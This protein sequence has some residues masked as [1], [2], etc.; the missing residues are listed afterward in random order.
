MI[1]T[2]LRRP[3]VQ[4]ITGLS[5]AGIYKLM[6]SGKFPEPI[7][8]TSRAVRWKSEEIQ[9]WIESRPRATGETGGK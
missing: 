2:L 9:S 4:A 1:H 7:K 6:R 3:E 8:V 5:C